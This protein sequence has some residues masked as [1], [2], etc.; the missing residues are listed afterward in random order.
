M[1]P[2][3]AAMKYQRNVY[4]DN[5]F[6]PPDK[7]ICGKRTYLDFLTDQDLY[8]SEL[9]QIGLNAA[10]SFSGPINR[11]SWLQTRSVSPSPA[12]P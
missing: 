10:R 5:F 3:G 12:N 7:L 11:T 9:N 6:T 1:V 2:D 4:L 8:M